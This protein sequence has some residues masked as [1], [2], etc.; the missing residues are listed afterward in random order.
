MQRAAYISARAA[1]I[2]ACAARARSLARLNRKL[3]LQAAVRQAGRQAGPLVHVPVAHC[4]L[5]RFI[6]R[7][8][9]SQPRPLTRPRS[10]A[11]N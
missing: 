4:V 1:N 8:T 9:P 3:P 2:R 6:L 11:F 7:V 5:S 10:R